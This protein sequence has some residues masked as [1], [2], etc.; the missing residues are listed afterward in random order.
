VRV[1]ISKQRWN[2]SNAFE[3]DN[4]L[5]GT[6]LVNYLYN[7]VGVADSHCW[8]RRWM[9]VTFSFHDYAPTSFE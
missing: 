1:L 6:L 2:R 7:V 4:K 3:H 8:E 9:H 5:V